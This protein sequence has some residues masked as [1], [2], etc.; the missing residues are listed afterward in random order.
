MH[1]NYLPTLHKFAKLLDIL[2]TLA[3]KEELQQKPISWIS[4]GQLNELRASWARFRGE[5]WIRKIFAA[6]QCKLSDLGGRT[7]G[8]WIYAMFNTHTKRMYVGHTTQYLMKRYG[9]HWRDYNF[10]TQRNAYRY[11]RKIGGFEEWIMVPLEFVTNRNRIIEVTE[12]QWIHRFRHHCINDPIIWGLKPVTNQDKHRS[13]RDSTKQRTQHRMLATINYRQQ[14][15]YILHQNGWK[16][17]EP[18]TLV[19]HLYHIKIA[20]LNTFQRRSVNDLV[21]AHLKKQHHIELRGEY[22]CKLATDQNLPRQEIRS[23]LSRQIRQHTNHHIIAKYICAHMEVV[24]TSS[25]TLGD[26]IGNKAIVLEKRDGEPQCNCEHWN[27][28]KIDGHVHTKAKDLPEGYADLRNILALSKKNPVTFEM[29]DY[30]GKQCFGIRT[31]L[32]KINIPTQWNIEEDNRLRE[33][34]LKNWKDNTLEELQQTHVAQTLR[35][36]KKSLVFVE[37]DKNANAWAI[38]CQKRYTELVLSHFGNTDNYEKINKPSTT[39][40]QEIAEKYKGYQLDK[41]FKGRKKWELGRA[42]LLPKNKDITRFRP[43]VSYAKFHTRTIGKLISRALTVL[44]RILKSKWKTMELDKTKDFIATLNRTMA[45]SKWKE[46]LA[47]DITMVKWDIKNQFTNLPK[48]KVLVALEMAL[49]QLHIITK[50]KHFAIRRRATEKKSDRVGTGSPR[51]WHTI[52]FDTVLNYAKMELETPFIQ[53]GLQHVKQTEGLPMGGFLSAGLAVIYSMY[54]EE[55]NKQQW[56]NLK[57]KSKWFRFR[58]DIL[59]ILEGERPQYQIQQIQEAL[60]ATYGSELTVELEEVANN[61]MVFLDYNIKHCNNRLLVWNYNKNGMNSDQSKN[62]TRF[63]EVHSAMERTVLKGMVNGV[64]KKVGRDSNFDGG[65]MVGIIQAAN[66]FREKDYPI[67]WIIKHLPNDLPH[68]TLLKKLL[69]E[70][71]ISS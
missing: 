56:R 30:L 22:T 60:Q 39:I 17:W 18:R 28:P 35:P 61:D 6:T 53:V 24:G 25:K 66:E 34:L 47:G 50:K 41:F 10:D 16:E 32:K 31:F 58:D 23:W 4:I 69:K 2:A 45:T 68:R 48:K 40:K 15:N 9:Q 3:I 71:W 55:M 43:L 51:I 27:M 29:G 26:M 70:M 52:S 38:L 7:P 11:M 42:C 67:S 49:H 21:R 57:C 59:V 33:I 5:R 64:I 63:P 13:I 54:Q 46:V 1:L 62:T 12:N 8:W 65:R 20:K 14:A 19:K 37:L 36:F 44:I